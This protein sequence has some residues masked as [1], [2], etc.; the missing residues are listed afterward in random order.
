MSPVSQL[1]LRFL[2]RPSLSGEN[3]LVAANNRDAVIWLDRWPDW[4]APALAIWGPRGC[5]KTHLA[6]VFLARSGA[7]RLEPADLAEADLRELLRDAPVCVLDDAPRFLDGRGE[8]ALLH[9]YN[10]VAETNR[11]MLMTAEH[12]P[13]HWTVRLADLRSRLNAADAVGIGAPDDALIRAV[14]VKQFADRQLTVDDESLDYMLTRMERSFDAA[15]RLVAATDDAALRA[16]RRVT[17]PLIRDVLA[18]E[19]GAGSR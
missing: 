11:R 17:V 15:R 4:P 19:D 8:Q 9:L 16:K 14:L 7:R 2:Y 13:A 5:G 1:A 10:T 12:P 3:F 6:E 18:G